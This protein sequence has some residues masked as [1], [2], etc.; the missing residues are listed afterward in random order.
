MV[1]DVFSFCANLCEW[2][3]NILTIII[4]KF[5]DFEPKRDVHIS[6]G[7]IRTSNEQPKN[8][9]NVE[10]EKCLAICVISLETCCSTRMLYAHDFV[11][12]VLEYGI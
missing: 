7:K 8:H 9:E 12:T 4:C 11:I 3:N 2:Y 10:S 1:I 6:C 5:G